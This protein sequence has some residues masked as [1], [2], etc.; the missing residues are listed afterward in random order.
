MTSEADGKADGKIRIKN[1]LVK[2]EADVQW[3]RRRNTAFT[4]LCWFAIAGIIVW[5]ASQIYQALIVLVMACA[6]AYALYPLVEQLRRW[7]PSWLAILLVYLTLFAVV[8]GFGY[9]LVSIAVSELTQHLKDIQKAFTDNGAY[10]IVKGQLIAHGVTQEQIK[11]FTGAITDALGSFVSGLPGRLGSIVGGI[12]NGVLDTVL[13][14]VVSVYLVI[15]GERLAQWANKSTPKSYRG[16][17]TAVLSGMQRV[18]GGYIR[19]ELSMALLIGVLVGVGMLAFHVPFAPLLGLLAFVLEFV[20]IIGTLISGAVC[21][22]VAVTQGWVIV[23]LVL[24]YFIVVHVIEGDILG[25]RVVG[26]AVG[27][28]PVVSII[29]LAAGA[30]RFGIWGALFAAPLA[31]LAQVVIV[32]LWQEW[33]KAHA[34]EFAED[35]LKAEAEPPP[36]RVPVVALVDSMAGAVILNEPG[37]ALNGH[38]GLAERSARTEALSDPDSVG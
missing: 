13:V 32:D 4:I 23:L 5:L 24:A 22:L 6:L 25:P 9:L 20:P 35:L 8:G 2:T 29:A 34:D 36:E 33:R 1:V 26:R 14:V 3:I 30:E 19:G 17:I 31:G 38:D 28:H 18:V 11:G 21:V 7:L 10:G 37:P 16:H 12:A 15:D 27:L